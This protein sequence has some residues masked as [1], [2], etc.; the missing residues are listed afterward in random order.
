MT[1]LSQG[2]R[3]PQRTSREIAL[4]GVCWLLSLVFFVGQAL[5]QAAWRIPYHPLENLISD[6]GSTACQTVRLG[7]YHAYVCSPWHAVMNSAFIL[8]G[9]LVWLGLYLTRRAWP[10]RRLSTWG[11]VFL[12]LAG[13]GK[14]V[15]GLAPENVN[16]G[17]HAL[18]SLG[19]L[20]ANSGLILLGFALWR[21][22]RWV[23]VISLVLGSLGWL[24][25]VLFVGSSNGATERLADY[26]AVLWMMVLGVAFV[27]W[28]WRNLP[29][30]QR[31]AP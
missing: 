9:L 27:L 22:C 17:L 2:V 26:P 29:E 15:V 11:L 8:T 30:M 20:C 13:L 3:F 31:T 7:S 14:I 5:A 18:G 6:L 23:A 25:L 16:P 4:G 12:T 19:I 21:A 24:G 1:E 10:Q 28:W